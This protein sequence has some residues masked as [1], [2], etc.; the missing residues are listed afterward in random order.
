MRLAAFSGSSVFAG[1]ER[2]L[3]DLLANLDPAIDITLLGPDAAVRAELIRRRRG[4]ARWRRG[5][6]DRSDVAA[7]RRWVGALRAVR[8][9]ILQLNLTMPWSCRLETLLAV[10]MPGVRVV[11]V[12]HSPLPFDRE[13]MRRLKFLLA[14]GYAAHVAVGV[15]AARDIERH[16]GLRPGSVR[17]IPVGVEP[18]AADRR[19][20]EGPP[21]IGTIACLDPLKRLDDSCARWRCCP[22]SS[23]R[24]SASGPEMGRLTALAGELGVADRTRFAGWSEGTRA[25]LG[26]AGSS[27]PRTRAT[28]VGEYPRTSASHAAAAAT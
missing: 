8:P 2:M 16:A 5:I 24:S 19:E 10:A 22:A 18:F 25:W 17:A 12:E 28:C 26:R 4:R 23:S 3:G 6:D 27:N 9:D 7:M 20:R 13:S 11:A 14:A 21:R 1:A 15:Q